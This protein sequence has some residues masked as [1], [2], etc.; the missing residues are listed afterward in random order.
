MQTACGPMHQ[1]KK[2]KLANEKRTVENPFTMFEYHGLA[3]WAAQEAE[4]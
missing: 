4:K 1:E 2:I 3:N